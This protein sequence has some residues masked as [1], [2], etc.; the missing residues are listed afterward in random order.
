MQ[1]LGKSILSSAKG[2]KIRKMEK[3]L[4][5]DVIYR[6]DGELF[7]CPF[8]KYESKKNR[9]GTAKIFRDEK[10]ISFKCFA[11]GKWRKIK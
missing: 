11:C 4:G 3:E 10:G 8:C 2:L 5:K 7:L 1:K 6:K 9:K